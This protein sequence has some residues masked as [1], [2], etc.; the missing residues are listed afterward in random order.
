[1]DCGENDLAFADDRVDVEDI[2]G[3]KLFEEKVAL[4][5]A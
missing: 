1:M 4:A 5:V 3:D 2:A